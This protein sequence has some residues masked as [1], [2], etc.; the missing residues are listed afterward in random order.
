[1]SKGY[2]SLKEA[3]QYQNILSRFYS[4]AL[5]YLSDTD[6]TL[7]KCSTYFYSKAC[8]TAQDETVEE[9]NTNVMAGKANDLVRF[10][11]YLMGQKEKLAKEIAATKRTATVDIDIDTAVNSDRQSFVRVLQRMNAQKGS[12]MVIQNGATGYTFNNEGNQ[13]SYCCDC[14]TVTMIDF[15][16]KNVAHLLGKYGELCTD[17]SSSIDK[18][19]VG[20]YVYYNPVFGVYDSFEEIFDR[21][22]N[23]EIVEEDNTPEK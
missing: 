17:T 10:A 20:G 11:E 3:F 14:K 23:G 15:D 16:R 22:V 19:L 12:E 21:F 5:S 8:K 9:V 7:K 6:V 18:A 1:M 2:L 4:Q 13:V